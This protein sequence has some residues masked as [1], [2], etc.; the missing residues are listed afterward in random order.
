MYACTYVCVLA[1][2]YVFMY[3]CMDACVRVYFVLH[4][5]SA[6]YCCVPSAVLHERGA[7]CCWPDINQEEDG[8]GVHLGHLLVRCGIMSGRLC[9]CEIVYYV[10]VCMYVCLLAC[11]NVC[12]C[13]WIC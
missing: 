12:M 2:M 6:E 5:W 11:M 1:C 3:A 8:H 10:C 9:L 13:F 4:A 7:W